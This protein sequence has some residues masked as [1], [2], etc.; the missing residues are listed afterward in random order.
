M[1]GKE[2]HSPQHTRRKARCMD[3]Q[4][5]AVSFRERTSTPVRTWLVKAKE[6]ITMAPRSQQVVI[7]RL[8]F[9]QEQEPH[10]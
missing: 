5:T 7:G 6:N 8:E 9:Q 2:W 1:E 3:K 4:V 10:P